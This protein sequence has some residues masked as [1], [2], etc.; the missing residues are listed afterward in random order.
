MYRHAVAQPH[1][2]AWMAFVVN[3]DRARGLIRVFERARERGR[4]RKDDT[5]LPLSSIV[6]SIGA[7]DAYLHDLVL[8]VVTDHVP[9]SEEL[10]RALKRLDAEGLVLSMARARNVSGSRAAFKQALDDYFDDRSFMGIAG[11]L[12]A[13]RLVGCPRTAEELAEA[14]GHERFAV[15]LEAFT[16]MRHAI[17]HRGEAVRMRKKRAWECVKL[18]EDVVTVIDAMVMARYNPQLRL[19]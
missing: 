9:Q 13:L 14:T 15:E 12:R 2:E 19:A 10:V 8:S 16:E 17:V 6:Y 18:V 11:V 4:P 1:T 3:I 5:E 7:L